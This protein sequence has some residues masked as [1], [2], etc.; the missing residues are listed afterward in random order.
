MVVRPSSVAN[1]ALVVEKASSRIN[2]VV[3]N[4]LVVSVAAEHNA[5][6]CER[7]ERLVAPVSCNEPMGPGG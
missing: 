5:R 4:E 2:L 6:N 7:D 1:L 3:R